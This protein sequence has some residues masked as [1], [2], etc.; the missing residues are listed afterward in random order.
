[1]YITTHPSPLGLLTLASDGESLSG[2]WIAEQK[3]HGTESADGESRGFSSA[4]KAATLSIFDETAAWLERYFGGEKP[5]ID[6]LPLAPQGSDF[7]RAVWALLCEIPY[8]AVTSYGALARKMGGGKNLARAVGGAVGH[9]P[10]SIIIPCHRVVGA[11]GSLVGYAGGLAVKR[12]LLEL[13][14]SL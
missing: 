9:N 8:G 13:E 12:R 3:Y 7:R 5:A 1:M 11:D 14:G 2:L 6:T 10:I 4:K